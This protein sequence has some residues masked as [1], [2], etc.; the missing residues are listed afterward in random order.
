MKETAYPHIIIQKTIEQVR[1]PLLQPIQKDIFFQ[2]I[3]LAPQLRKTPRPVR[4]ARKVRWRDAC[5]HA[6]KST[7]RDTKLSL[8]IELL[9]YL[10]GVARSIGDGGGG[11]G[12]E[13]K[14]EIGGGC[15]K[16]RSHDSE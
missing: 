7:R 4:G 12:A 16:D 11:A 3:V 15:F 2:P 10:G 6:R 13:V 8:H 14:G 5:E 1:V 9:L